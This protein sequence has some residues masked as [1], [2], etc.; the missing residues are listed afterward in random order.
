MAHGLYD[1]IVPFAM[2]QKT[3]EHLQSLQYSV[4]W[5]TYSMQHT[6]VP[7][8]IQDINYCLNR[9]LLK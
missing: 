8:E 2:G 3:K 5:H 7:E 1:P 6:V 4:D 9:I